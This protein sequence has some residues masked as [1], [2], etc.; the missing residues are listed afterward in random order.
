[1]ATITREPMRPYRS[2]SIGNFPTTSFFEATS[3]SVL[4][5]NNVNQLVDLS[6]GRIRKANAT[7]PNASLAASVTPV[8]IVTE[9]FTNRTA[10]SNNKNTQLEVYTTAPPVSFRANVCLNRADQSLTAAMVGSKYGLLN[11]SSGGGSGIWTVNFGQTTNTYV[12]VL[13]LIDEIGDVNGAV[14]F[15]FENDKVLPWGA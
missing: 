15:T 12:T 1:M 8:G 10:T 3:Q 2:N 11:L 7:A 9:P 6:S 5:G 4:S 14:E 13:S